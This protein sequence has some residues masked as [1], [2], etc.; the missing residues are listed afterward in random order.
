[1]SETLHFLPWLRRG[2]G[3]TLTNPDPGSGALP[4]N[5]PIQAQVEINDDDTAVATLSLR[6]VDHATGIDPTQIVRRYPVARQRRR[7]ARL[8]PARRHLGP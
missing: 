1:M 6:P 5:A 3:L 7:R 2:L 4:R 8:L